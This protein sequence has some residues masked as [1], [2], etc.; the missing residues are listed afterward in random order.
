MDSDEYWVII[1][2]VAEVTLYK[3]EMRLSVD[4]T[5]EGMTTE[6]PEFGW[7]ASFG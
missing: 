2:L 4:Q 7:N 3:G 1:R 5:S 6:L